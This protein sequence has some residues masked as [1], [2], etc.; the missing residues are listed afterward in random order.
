[1]RFAD[2]PEELRRE[3]AA[4]WWVLEC[5]AAD[6]FDTRTAAGRW[7]IIASFFETS[8]FCAL[9]NYMARSDAVTL[10]D[11]GHLLLARSRALETAA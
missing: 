7:E 3:I 4:E 10:R 2:L 5:E 9:Q 8:P 1:M 11:L 6:Y